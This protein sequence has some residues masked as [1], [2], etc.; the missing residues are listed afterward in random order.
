MAL[1][2]AYYSK[3]SSHYNKVSNTYTRITLTHSFDLQF[4][5]PIFRCGSFWTTT[6]LCA[7]RCWRAV[8]GCGVGQGR[9][10]CSRRSIGSRDEAESLHRGSLAV[11]RGCSVARSSSRSSSSSSSS[12]QCRSA[13]EYVSHISPGIIT[14]LP[15][16]HG[17]T[18][19]YY[20][21]LLA[22][23]VRRGAA[24]RGLAASLSRAAVAA[25]AGRCRNRSNHQKSRLG[26]CAVCS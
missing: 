5:E 21:L 4:R 8:V 26:Q 10:R 18:T 24:R 13:A 22:P 25:V 2:S 6:P 11:T 1:S 17:P 3:T 19:Y 7:G 9:D 16:N 15:Y 12:V 14:A 23:A 20:C